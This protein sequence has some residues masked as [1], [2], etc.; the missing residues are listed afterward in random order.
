MKRML[1]AALCVALIAG[2]AVAAVPFPAEAMSALG[3]PVVI[4]MAVAAGFTNQGTFT[5]DGILASTDNLVTRK[6]TLVSGE[7]RKRGTVLGK[8][9][10]GGAATA[11][12]P[13][14]AGIGGANTGNG[15]MT[16]AN[17]A[18]G[19]GVKAGTYRV[20]IVEAAANAGTFQVE[21][22]DGIIV[23]QGTVGAAF[24]GV[25]KF[26]IA[27]GAT[28]FVAG[29]G[30]TVA[31]TIAAPSNNGKY[32]MSA[33]AAVD[34]SQAPVVI[35]AEDCDASAADKVTIA[36]FAGNFD[37]NGLT[38]GTGWTAS[39]VREALRDLGINLHF[40]VPR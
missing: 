13:A 15:A 22:P 38:Y 30:F 2:L 20:T 14:A 11:G 28:D 36:H 40:S 27:D 1:C 35:L 32:K 23:G 21:D 26:T 18:T 33:S 17:P 24:D 34:G 25:I 4:A 5:P 16:M 3:A 37:E 29:D 8:I 39:G 12:A 9:T 19:A 6:I 7:N 10:A 31:I